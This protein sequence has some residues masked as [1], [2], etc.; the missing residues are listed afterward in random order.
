MNTS[1]VTRPNRTISK[2]LKRE[3]NRSLKHLKRTDQQVVTA[4]EKNET[5][6]P[7]SLTKESFFHMKSIFLDCYNKLKG[8]NRRIFAAQ[9]AL[10]LG[11]GGQVFISHQF[12]ISR[13]T[14]RKAIGE[15]KSGIPITDK[16]KQRHRKRIE[17]HLPNLLVDIKAICDSQSQ[18]D[19]TFKSTRLF[20]RLTVAEIR[21]QLIE[22][23][24][25]TDEEL[26][27]NQTLNTK[28]NK[29]GYN[30]KKVRKTKPLKKN[31]AD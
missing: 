1:D 23:K 6:I 30:L 21:R 5:D 18:T 7:T 20:T 26:P 24:G 31:Q 3:E 11:K 19:P 4:A 9:L 2:V 8:R 29:L 22:K 12:K 16:F 13:T 17:E 25:Y 28:V 10:A 27:T 14:L 15:I